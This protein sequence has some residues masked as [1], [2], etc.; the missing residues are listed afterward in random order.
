[1]R[2][3]GGRSRGGLGEL[4]AHRE[5]LPTAARRGRRSM[6]VVAW[7][8]GRRRHLGGRRGVGRWWGACGGKAKGGRCSEMAA[9][10]EAVPGH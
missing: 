7:L 6:T 4:K 1:M 3:D 10:M 8:G 9:H 2:A 5:G